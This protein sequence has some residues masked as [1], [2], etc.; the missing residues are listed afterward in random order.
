MYKP[1]NL[2]DYKTIQFKCPHCGANVFIGLKLCPNC[3]SKIKYNSKVGDAYSIIYQQTVDNN[4][5]FVREKLENNYKWVYRGIRYGIQWLLIL[6]IILCHKSISAQ[7]PDLIAFLILA[8]IFIYPIISAVFLMPIYKYIIFPIKSAKLLLKQC[9]KPT[10]DDTQWRLEYQVTHSQEVYS[11][12]VK[13]TKGLLGD[14]SARE[15]TE[16]VSNTIGQYLNLPKIEL[17]Q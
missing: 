6:I 1:F 15:S 2:L 8:C 10:Y 11:G 9:G 14:W 3:R 7:G 12:K 5:P 17:K 4:Y 16:I 13:L